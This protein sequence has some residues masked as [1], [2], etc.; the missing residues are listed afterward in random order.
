MTT[1]DSVLIVVASALWE[2]AGYHRKWGPFADTPSQHPSQEEGVARQRCMRAA[3]AV[4]ARLRTVP[5]EPTEQR[6]EVERDPGNRPTRIIIWGDGSGSVAGAP[7]GAGV[8]IR[9]EG[10][11][12]DVVGFGRYL[13]TGTN[14]FAELWALRL[15]L[16][17]IPEAYRTIPVIVRSDS[18]YAMGALSGRNKVH[19]NHEVVAD[20]K[21]EVVAFRSI[22]WQHVYG[23]TGVEENE[24]ADTMAGLAARQRRNITL[25]E[26]VRELALHPPVKRATRKRS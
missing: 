2:D 5:W 20:G 13:G 19:T 10:V 1:P 7:A 23:H 3:K 8:V 16:Q 26:A 11:K 17:A 25:E 22:D 4:L 12:S 9:Y 6:R 15:G 18:Q 14:N 21:A 24:W